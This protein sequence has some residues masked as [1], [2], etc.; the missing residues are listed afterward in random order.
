MR[1]NKID[2]SS[3]FNNFYFL[4]SRVTTDEVHF[5][6]TSAWTVPNDPLFIPKHG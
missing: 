2:Y 5:M 3:L 1:V 4:H 6:N